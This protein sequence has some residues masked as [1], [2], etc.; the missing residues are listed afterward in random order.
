MR[1]EDEGSVLETLKGGKQARKKNRIVCYKLSMTAQ[2]II[3][4]KVLSILFSR[5]PSLRERILPVKL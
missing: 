5:T 3:P 2:K 4:Q 1:P